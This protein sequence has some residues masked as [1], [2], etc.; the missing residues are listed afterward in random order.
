MAGSSFG[1]YELLSEISRG[2]MG[3]VFQARQRSLNRIV[4][5]KMVLAVGTSAT[6]SERFLVEAPPWHGSVIGTSCQSMKWASMA[7]GRFSRWSL[8]LA[9]A[10]GSG[11]TSFV[12]ISGPW[13]NYWRPWHEPSSMRIDAAFCI[14]T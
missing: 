1:D 9:A 12:A 13:H 4:A 6:D 14:A 2:G 3:V 5:L 10:Y 11:L 8:S 7:G